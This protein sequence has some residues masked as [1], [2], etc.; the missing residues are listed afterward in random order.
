[1][2]NYLFRRLNLLLITAFVLTIITFA[3]NN[4]SAANAT[5]QAHYIIRYFDYIAAIVQGEWGLSAIDQQPI[6]TTGLLAFAATLELCFIAFIIATVI[7]IP[8]GILAGLNRHRSHDHIIMAIVLVGLALPVFWLAILSTMLPTLTGLLLP[9]GGSL[10]PAFEIANIS[11]FLL[12][13][14]LLA[15]DTYHLDAFFNRLAHLTLPAAVLSFF[16]T[17]EMTRLTRD[18]ITAIMKSNYIKA[19]YAKGLSST[20]IVIT[21]VLKN[22]LPSVIHQLRLKLSTIISFAMVI[23]IVFSM[24]GAGDWLFSSIKAGDYIALPTAVLLISGFILL[25]SI[26]IDILLVIISPVKRKSLYVD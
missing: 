21:H 16:L 25:T 12:I 9:A 10:S 7:A 17:A 3:L 22:A 5:A 8:L 23:E 18:S 6:L 24:N 4:W 14:T 26:F 2:L 1:M 20:Q 15:A 11:G 19:A 13:D